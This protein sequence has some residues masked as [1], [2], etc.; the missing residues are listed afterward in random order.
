M[1]PLALI[2]CSILAV[3]RGESLNVNP[4][5]KNHSSRH[6]ICNQVVY[7]DNVMFAYR[8]RMS[9]TSL[10]TTILHMNENILCNRLHSSISGHDL[11]CQHCNRKI[12]H[13]HTC[14]TSYHSSRLMSSKQDEI[15]PNDD[16]TTT[17]IDD[18]KD[19]HIDRPI[20]NQTDRRIDNPIDHAI[21]NPI[22]NPIDRP[23]D[24][25]LDSPIDNP[26]YR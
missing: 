23:I 24:N 9:T 25:H 15:D 12:H 4:V 16:G 8:N 18:H 26:V 20:D 13:N 21:A 22:Y 14:T 2:I 7:Q 3:E 5:V 19:N 1:F 10:P 6:K 11:R 17:H